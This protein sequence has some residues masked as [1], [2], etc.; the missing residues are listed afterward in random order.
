[1]TWYSSCGQVISNKGVA[2]YASVPT[3]A[4]TALFAEGL[5][6][7]K[8]G[9]KSTDNFETLIS[10]SR[11]KTTIYSQNSTENWCED[12]GE[13]RL[14]NGK[15]HID[16]DPLF[17]E[18]VT[19]TKRHPIKVFIQLKD[20]CNGVFVKDGKTGF[21]VIEMQNGKSN[22]TFAYRVVAKRIGYEDKRLENISVRTIAS[23]SS[24]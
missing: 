22:A 21:D 16:I 20:N 13:G 14:N 15:A 17:L 11:G 10:T 6:Y 4:D 2:F 9:Y 1:M 23:A 19:I 8:G 12:F 7:A 3:A 5:I 24:K 18:T